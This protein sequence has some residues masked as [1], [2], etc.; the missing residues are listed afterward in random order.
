MDMSLNKLWKL[1]MDQGVW[2]AAVH[3]VAKILTLLHDWTTII[4]LLPYYLQGN[5]SP[6]SNTM[7]FKCAWVCSVV[8]YL[9]NPM[10]MEFSSQAPLSVEFSRQQYWNG[11]PFP[12][13][14]DLPVPGIKPTSLVSPALAGW[15]STTEATCEAWHLNY[16]VQ[17][18][19]YSFQYSKEFFFP[20]KWPN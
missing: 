17:I 11:V 15:F 10:A 4:H 8:S 19:A 1:V 14:G 13:P 3:G 12:S 18:N 2:H 7:A 16:R 9:C 6:V 20:L 5:N